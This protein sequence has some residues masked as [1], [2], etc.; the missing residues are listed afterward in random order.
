MLKKILEIV[1]TIATKMKI[2]ASIQT[3]DTTVEKTDKMTELF[4]RITS[5]LHLAGEHLFDIIRPDGEFAK[6]CTKMRAD[7][8]I[9]NVTILIPLPD[10]ITSYGIEMAIPTIGYTPEISELRELVVECIDPV[11]ETIGEAFWDD[12]T[13]VETISAWRTATEI[14][15]HEQLGLPMRE[16][17]GAT[18]GGSDSEGGGHATN[19]DG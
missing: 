5:A 13:D 12:G 6:D 3:D 8:D 9:S 17:V 16:L 4:G 1:L 2:T 7:A 11:L 10:G 19:L 18:V 15:I 14:T